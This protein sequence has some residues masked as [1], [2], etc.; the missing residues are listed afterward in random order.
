MPDPGGI[1][2][3]TGG[4]GTIRLADAR[5]GLPRTM[6][7]D[8]GTRMRDTCPRCG[9]PCSYTIQND[10]CIQCHDA[11]YLARIAAEDAAWGEREEACNRL[12]Y[13]Y[14]RSRR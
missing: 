14:Q 4:N 1:L 11:A 8:D 12:R 13:L 5:R 3:P 9:R 2:L 6:D 7:T 10:Q